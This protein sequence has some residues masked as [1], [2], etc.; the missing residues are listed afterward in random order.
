M[1]RL[2]ES[3][4]GENFPGHA[5]TAEEVDFFTEKVCLLRVAVQFVLSKSVQDLP[6]IV[7]VFLNGF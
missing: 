5:Y 1:P 7:L 6:Y 3:R 2:T 4:F